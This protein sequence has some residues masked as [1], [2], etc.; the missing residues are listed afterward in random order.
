MLRLLACRTDRLHGGKS[1][2]RS[3][4][5]QTEAWLATCKQDFFIYSN[6]EP[7]CLL[8]QQYL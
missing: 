2:G 4:R 5:D 6:S 1:S 3:R 7:G 8:Y